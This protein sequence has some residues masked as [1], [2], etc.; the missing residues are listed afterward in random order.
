MHPIKSDSRYAITQEYCG[1]PE[2][3]YVL[4]FCGEW[5][6]QSISKASMV[7][8]AVGHKAMRNGALVVT[9]QAN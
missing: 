8:R 1:Y 9:E 2:P 5:I 4:R 7:T 3:R 6:A